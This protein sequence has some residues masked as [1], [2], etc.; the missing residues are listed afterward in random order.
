VEEAVKR[1]DPR[2]PG[3][4]KTTPGSRRSRA[5]GSSLRYR[6]FTCGQVERYWTRAERHSDEQRHHRIEV[7]F[8]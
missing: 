1:R 7:L 3:F 5:G 4:D 6:C 2:L 8:S